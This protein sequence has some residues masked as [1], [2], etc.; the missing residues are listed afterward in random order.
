MGPPGPF[1]VEGPAGPQGLPGLNGLPGEMGLQGLPGLP[2]P[3]GDRGDRGEPG[4]CSCPVFGEPGPR[5][6]PGLVGPPGPKVRL[7]TRDL[8][9]RYSNEC[10]RHSGRSRI[11]VPGL[12]GRSGCPASGSLQSNAVC[13][14]PLP[15]LPVQREPVRFTAT[16]VV[17]SE[18]LHDYR[19]FE[20]SAASAGR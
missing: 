20:Q 3:I 10:F 19:S 1:G 9:F 7:L 14:Q 15:A 6:L 18:W 16:T 2:G 8:L 12:S 17:P 4:N 11:A 5:G 13:Q